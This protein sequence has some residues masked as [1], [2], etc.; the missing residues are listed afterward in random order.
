MQLKK[1]VLDRMTKAELEEYIFKLYSVLDSQNEEIGALYEKGVHYSN[2]YNA[3]LKADNARARI[4]Y[5]NRTIS[6]YEG[7]IIDKYYDE[8]REKK[9]K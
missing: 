1:T 5:L 9:E 7:N 2:Y 3:S 4:E 8:N 6:S